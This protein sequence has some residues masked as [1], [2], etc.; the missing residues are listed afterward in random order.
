MSLRTTNKHYDVSGMEN[1]RILRLLLLW[2]LLRLDDISGKPP[3]RDLLQLAIHHHF[4][5]YIAVVTVKYEQK[6]MK[7]LRTFRHR[8]AVFLRR[9]GLIRDKL[10]GRL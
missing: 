5:R 4:G 9:A 2:K 1:G 3:L 7:F 6:W 10:L 8:K